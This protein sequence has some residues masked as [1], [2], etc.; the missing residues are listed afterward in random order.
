MLK[1]P[2]EV[3]SP[4]AAKPMKFSPETLRSR[5]INKGDHTLAPFA[6]GT[7]PDAVMLNIGAKEALGTNSDRLIAGPGARKLQR[8]EQEDSRRASSALA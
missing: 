2:R 4:A 6:F 8:R 7:R 5:P 3:P 1:R